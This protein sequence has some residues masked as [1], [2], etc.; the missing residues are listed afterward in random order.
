MDKFTKKLE[1]YNVYAEFLSYNSENNNIITKLYDF[2]ID[3]YEL[4]KNDHSSQYE[5]YEIEQCIIFDKFPI[6]FV[7]EIINRFIN[8]R[9]YNCIVYEEVKKF[10]Y[11]HWNDEIIVPEVE[12]ITKI[13]IEVANF[14]RDDYCDIMRNPKNPRFNA[15][16]HYVYYVFWLYCFYP[17]LDNYEELIIKL[18][19]LVYLDDAQDELL[20]GLL[21][22]SS[23]KLVNFYNK[24]LINVS[25]SRNAINNSHCF[26]LWSTGTGAYFQNIE[27]IKKLKS[28]LKY[29]IF[30]DPCLENFWINEYN[31]S[32]IARIKELLQ[33]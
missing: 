11:K 21:H 12:K 15:E 3:F 27:I 5:N 17:M 18:I 20:N 32:Q 2:I 8:G 30:N 13:L 1:L 19:N 28:E 33:T 24:F 4:P 23:E 25:E 9:I 26:D 7:K 16:K 14:T 22:I 29:D 31:G 6:D 10:L